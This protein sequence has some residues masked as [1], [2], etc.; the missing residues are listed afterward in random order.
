LAEDE[1]GLRTLV[2]A[3]R[4]APAPGP[5][6]FSSVQCEIASAQFLPLCWVFFGAMSAR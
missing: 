3:E 1:R 2:P 4:G 5:Q 6:D